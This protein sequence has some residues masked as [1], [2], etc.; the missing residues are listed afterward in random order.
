MTPQLIYDVGMHRGEDTEYYL[1]R[2]H[3]VVGIE[4]NPNLVAELRIRF[5]SQIEAGQLRIVDRAINSQPGLARFA[6][7]QIKSVWGTLNDEFVARNEAAGA[8][9][10]FIEVECMTF[11][12]ILRENGMP[13]YLKIDIEGCDLLCIEALSGFTEKPRYVSLESRVTSPQYG[14]RDALAEIRLL[15]RLGYRRFKYINQAGISNT[16]YDLRLEGEPITYTFPG[17]SSG[18]FG[19]ETPGGWHSF[20]VADS[21][22]V[23]LRLLDHICAYNGR[24]KKLPGAR[25]VRKA[26][27]LL[28][29][30]ADP[31][32]DLHASIG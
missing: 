3:R 23:T 19:A 32:Y 24:F 20:S 21:I 31:W 16:T 1:R 27:R 10:S 18:P 13:Y 9:S 28:T 14:V 26:R 22:G 29:W 2:G 15:R 30:H 17:E 4:A 5:N 7:N 8:P 6:I 12:E 11:D 25:L